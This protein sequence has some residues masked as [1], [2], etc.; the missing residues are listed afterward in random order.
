[1]ATLKRKDNKGRI[2]KDG[3][4]Q[5]KDGSYRFRYTDATGKRHDIY[6]NRLVPT[7][8]T[9]KGCKDDLSLREKEKLINRDLDDGIKAKVENNATLNDFFDLYMSTKTNLK[10]SVRT[11]Y[12]YMYNRFVRGSLG[13]KRIS[14][15]KY[16]DIKKFYNS[17]IKDF[18][19]KPNSMEIIHTLLHPTCKLAVR[20]NCIRVNPTSDV[21]SEIKKEHNWEKT[22]RIAL[23]VEEQTAFI[24]FVANS[25]TYKR[26]LPLFATFLGTGGRVGE[27]TGLRWED[28]DFEDM[29]ISINHS[30]IYRQYLGEPESCFHVTSPK[31]TAGTRS[32]P[33]LPDVKK[34][35][36]QEYE[37][38]KVFGFNDTIVDGYSGFI[39]QNRYGNV[40]SA[41]NINRAID[42]ILLA[43]NTDEKKKAVEEGRE[44]LLIR[45]FSVHN[46]RHTFCTRLCE[47]EINPKVIQEIMGH[48]S[49]ETT[50]DI[51][52]EVT[53]Q[54]KRE[55]AENLDGKIKIL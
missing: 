15:I 21:M 48:A 18:G 7:D 4:S 8:K 20:D 55:F 10:E 16:S 12:L 35:L 49:I 43:Y 33:M 13:E 23:T 9:P 28:C 46:L 45:H 37:Y 2:L 11:N 19:L 1:M 6:S 29:S 22:K 14:T 36:M 47:K 38:Q 40:M 52:A 17:L 34:A 27:I 42:R 26:W 32:I 54:K 3:E 24:N 30:L 50:L 5:R 51:Y 31:T 25:P 53:E 39:F 41:H 44:P